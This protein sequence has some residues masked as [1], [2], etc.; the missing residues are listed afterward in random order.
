LI[1]S[2]LIEC[3]KVNDQV[4]KVGYDAYVAY[5]FITRISAVQAIVKGNVVV[6]N[7]F[8]KLDQIF[9]EKGEL[10]QVQCEKEHLF[11]TIINPEKLEIR[12][13]NSPLHEEYE[14]FLK[15]GDKQ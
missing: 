1:D 12:Y 5:D 14:G 13:K 9:T 3:I 8:H 2:S 10:L 4:F 15:K 6:V 7:I 11:K